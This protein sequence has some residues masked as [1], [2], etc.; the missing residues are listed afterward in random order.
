MTSD[1]SVGL[2]STT[3]IKIKLILLNEMRGSSFVGNSRMFKLIVESSCREGSGC[4]NCSNLR[5]RAQ[6][7][8]VQLC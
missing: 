2:H 8:Y 5:G 1:S 6:S 4:F 3:E 7:L